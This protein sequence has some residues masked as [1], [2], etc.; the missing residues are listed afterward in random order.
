MNRYFQMLVWCTRPDDDPRSAA[1]APVRR[2][3][4]PASG[5]DWAHLERLA[6]HHGCLPRLRRR[7]GEASPDAMPPEVSHRM[8]RTAQAHA[9]KNALREQRAL[10]IQDLLAENGVSAMIFKGPALAAI[11]YE[12]PD[13]RVYDDLDVLVRPTDYPKARGTLCR[14]GYRPRVRLADRFAVAHMR[15]G[16]DCL[17]DS[18]DGRDMVELSTGVAPRHDVRSPGQELWDASRTVK[19]SDGTV[20]TPASEVLLPLLCVHAAKHEWRRLAWLRDMAGLVVREKESL[21]WDRVLELACYYRCRR[22]LRIGL[23]LLQKLWDVNL[24]ERIRAFLDTDRAVEPLAAVAMRR[25]REDAARFPSLRS[26]LRFQWQQ[27]D[28]LIERC[29]YVSLWA[30]TPSFGDWQVIRLPR[31][32]FFLYYLIRPPRLLL[33]ASKVAIRRFS[34]ARPH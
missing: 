16:W 17:M 9:F 20:H 1:G 6:A 8:L 30:L 31:A 25:L 3:P 7:L 24:P 14:A 13:D 2:P 18:P 11:A 32:L 34:R 22:R 26:R 28:G 15:A 23:R 29:R 12:H 10:D 33:R 5:V 19:L 27:R 4:L 21:D